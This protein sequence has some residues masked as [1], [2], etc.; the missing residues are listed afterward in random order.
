MVKLI[1][2][3]LESFEDNSGKL[4]SKKIVLF[5]FSLVFMTLSCVYIYILT[6]CNKTPSG[7]IEVYAIVVS[8]LLIQ[9]GVNVAYNGIITKIISGKAQQSKTRTK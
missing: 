8:S 9:I 2:K 6:T 5:L 4:S 3:I 7:F 1:N